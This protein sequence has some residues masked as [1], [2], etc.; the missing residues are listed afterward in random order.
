MARRK[1]ISRSD[2][3]GDKGIALIHRLVLDMGFVWNPTGLEAGI[4]GYIEIRDEATGEVTNCILQVQSK[5]TAAPFAAETDTGFHFVCDERDLDYWLGGNAPVIL[6]VSL[7]PTQRSLLG[8]HQGL[9][10]RP[11]TVASNVASS[12]TSV[13][14][15]LTVVAESGWRSWRSRPSGPLPSFAPPPRATCAQSLAC[16]RFSTPLVPGENAVSEAGLVCGH[17]CGPLSSIQPANRARARRLLVLLPR[18]HV[19]AV[20][21]GLQRRQG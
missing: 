14:T 9:L 16:G 3:I 19:Q 20:V 18:P 6:I 17:G 11:R 21:A 12:S 1:K 10:Q 7:V 15:D 2:I 4:D 5:A 8:I 13:P